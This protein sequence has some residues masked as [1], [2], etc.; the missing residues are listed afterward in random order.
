MERRT[1]AS[2][3]GV[4]SRSSAAPRTPRAEIVWFPKRTEP[5]TELA[6]PQWEDQTVQFDPSEADEKTRRDTPE[7]AP[8]WT[9]D[10]RSET[11]AAVPRTRT[12]ARNRRKVSV[13]ADAL[14]HH[15]KHLDRLLRGDAH[16]LDGLDESGLTEIAVMGHGLYEQGRM[17]EARVVF[18]GLVTLEPV[19]P[20]PYTVL[21]AICLAEGDLERALS[22]FER[23]VELD[24]SDPA[25]LVYRGEVRL[26]LG[27]RR[28]A[29]EDLERALALP[30]LE[31]GDPFRERA[32]GALRAARS[33][34][35]RR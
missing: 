13:E 6:I 31:E 11:P 22:L 14:A 26:Q 18:E 4:R 21:G 30:G 34:G 35:R 33:S 32:E 27:K 23:A 25:A 8:R 2:R 3:S 20:F 16:A 29:V 19:E 28:A 12:P 10:R 15:R 5:R 24:E 1:R 17:Q 9:G 7:S